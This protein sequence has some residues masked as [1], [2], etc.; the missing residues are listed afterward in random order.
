MSL[1]ALHLLA[2]VVPSLLLS[3]AGALHRLAIDDAGARLRISTH[4]DPHPLAQGRVQSFPA[5]VDAP[6]P[7]VMVGMVLKGRELVRQ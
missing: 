2:T 7:E 5:T 6:G 3:H 1:S 4:K